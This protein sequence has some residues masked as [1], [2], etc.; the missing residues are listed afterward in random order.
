MPKNK[1]SLGKRIHFTQTTFSKT[2]E[3]VPTIGVIVRQE[4]FALPGVQAGEKIEMRCEDKI[5]AS[6]E[7]CN[8]AD[9]QWR[10]LGRGRAI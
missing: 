8:P 5:G 4:F 6:I 10:R 2:W 7:W 1:S 9:G 3:G